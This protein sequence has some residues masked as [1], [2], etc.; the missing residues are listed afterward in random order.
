VDHG[1]DRAQPVDLIGHRAG[2]VEV[3][4]VSDHG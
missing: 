2:L 1:V 3:G 4:Q